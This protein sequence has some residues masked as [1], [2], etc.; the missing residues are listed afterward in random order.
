MRDKAFFFVN[1]QLLRAYDT[2]L[3]TRTVY[4]QAARQGLFRY[5]VGRANAPAGTATAAVNAAEAAVL[6]ACNGTPP[7]NSPCIASYNIAT[8]PTG[9]GLDP[10]L[11]GFINAMPLP[12]NFTD[13]RWI[14]H[15][16]IQ[17][18]LRH[19]TRSS[20]TSS[21]SLTSICATTVWFTFVMRRAARALLAIRRTVAVRSFRIRQTLST[22]RA[23]RRISPST[24]AGHRRQL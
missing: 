8:N 13:R 2:A 5:V 1:L 19:S 12:N 22:L 24:G 10:T 9:V 14:E 7:T 21:A 4:T 6:P 23:L 18:S 17:F 3:V 11:V 16:G 15:G 20:T